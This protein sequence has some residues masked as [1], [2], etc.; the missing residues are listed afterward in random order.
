MGMGMR[1][2][3]EPLGQGG[4]AWT[5]GGRRRRGWPNTKRQ[6]GTPDT[7]TDKNTDRKGALTRGSYW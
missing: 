7:D 2:F 1:A 5:E 6:E 4:G 3:R